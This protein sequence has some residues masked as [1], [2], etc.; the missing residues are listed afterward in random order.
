MQT[1]ILHMTFSRLAHVTMF[2]ELLNISFK[3]WL[4]ISC[5]F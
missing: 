5:L 4:V 2:D 1:H 3:V